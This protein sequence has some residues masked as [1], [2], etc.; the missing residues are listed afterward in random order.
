MRAHS[1]YTTVVVAALAAVAFGAAEP[2]AA[3]SGGGSQGST[4]EVQPDSQEVSRTYEREVFIYP[5][6]GRRD[7]FESLIRTGQV[8]PELDGLTLRGIIYAGPNSVALLTDGS[9]TIYRVRRGDAVGNAR[10]IEIRP[11]EV[12]FAVDNLGVTQQRVMQMDRRD[13]SGGG[14]P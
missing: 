6:A 4:P 14:R 7:P 11:Q 1:R 13:G 8:G 9:G 3:Q 12:R 2:A 10:V 5:V